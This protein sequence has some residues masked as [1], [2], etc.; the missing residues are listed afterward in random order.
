[1]KQLYEAP[2]LTMVGTFEDVTQGTTVGDKT[3]AVMPANT[4][5]VDI[6]GFVATHL[7]S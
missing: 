6:P 4:P 3:D 5:V 1:M 7:T 2:T